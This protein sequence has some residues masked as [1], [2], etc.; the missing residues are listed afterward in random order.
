MTGWNGW[1]IRARMRLR[2]FLEYCHWLWL[3]EVNGPRTQPAHR[4]RT[5]K[6]AI[7]AM[8]S[9]SDEQTY[10]YGAEWRTRRPPASIQ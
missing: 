8:R 4:S 7:L 5:R 2:Q 9:S 10:R 1:E 3:S 6:P